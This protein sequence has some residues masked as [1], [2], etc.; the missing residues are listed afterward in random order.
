[1]S[2]LMPIAPRIKST[3]AALPIHIQRISLFSVFGSF[4]FVIDSSFF[5]SATGPVCA[6]H[7]R[8]TKPISGALLE[9][10]FPDRI[11]FRWSL[12]SALGW[13]L[14]PWRQSV[15]DFPAAHLFDYLHSVPSCFYDLLLPTPGVTPR[16]CSLLVTQACSIRHST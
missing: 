4:W 13:K 16:W 14:A 3:I 15:H 8:G 2:I 6:G 12:D 10:G 9:Q 7:K 1:M 11:S 5:G